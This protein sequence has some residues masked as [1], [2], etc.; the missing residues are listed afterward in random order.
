MRTDDD[1]EQVMDTWAG[2]E[3]RS[4]PDLHPTAEMYRMVR[5][6]ARRPP[7][8]LYLR[9][10]RVGTALA[11]LLLV[12]I[13]CTVVFTPSPGPVVAVGLRQGYAAEGDIVLRGPTLR[14][15][16]GPRRGAVAFNRLMLQLQA[17]DAS[18][19]EGI[20]PRVPGQERIA[21]APSDNYRLSLELAQ[22]GYLY[23]FQFTS[24]GTLVKLFPNE[25]YGPVRNP[26]QGG[27]PYYL[28]AEPNWFCLGEFAGEEHLYMIALT[29][30]ARELESLYARYSK[31]D[32]R[33]DQQALL[34]SLL[35][36]IEAADGW[37][38]VFDHR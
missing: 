31:A 9:W 36:A 33:A 4:A 16:K 32:Q 28:P 13:L 27:Q 15:E 20:D 21:L 2:E 8:P 5:A 34:S 10:A 19:V 26:L 23:V 14:P 12:A 17:Q 30:P 29:Q 7:V 3:T 35:Q 22:D 38:M 1:F 6:G 24:S 37:L 18:V 25:E 11:G